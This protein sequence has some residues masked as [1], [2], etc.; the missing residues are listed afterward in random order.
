EAE[1][2]IQESQARGVPGDDSH[3]SGT[4]FEWDETT[5]K[6]WSDLGL[7]AGGGVNDNSEQQAGPETPERPEMEKH[8][9]PETLMHS[10]RDASCLARSALKGKKEVAGTSSDDSRDDGTHRGGLEQVLA[11]G[12]TGSALSPIGEVR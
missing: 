4:P 3:S 12:A 8:F 7:W 10:F 2:E 11:G 6:S 1:G 5:A 9:L